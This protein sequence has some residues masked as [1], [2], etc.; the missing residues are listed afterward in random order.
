MAD[1]RS[2]NQYHDGYEDGY[3]PVE[4]LDLSK[5]DSFAEMLDA[6]RK[7]S[8]GARQLGEA[9]SIM[10]TRGEKEIGRAHV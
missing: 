6:Y 5:I 4:A 7:T 1:I 2:T 8:F 3:E 10:E 9:L